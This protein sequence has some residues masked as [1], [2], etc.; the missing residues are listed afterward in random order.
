MQEHAF[1]MWSL[2][3]L[4]TQLQAQTGD[5]YWAARYLGHRHVNSRTMDR[6]YVQDLRWRD[7]GAA[8][9]GRESVTFISAS[10]LAACRVPEVQCALHT[11]YHY[12]LLR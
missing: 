7:S 2:R 4:A 1:G 5:V 11:P 8:A 10:S 9:T 6:V 3:K 12:W